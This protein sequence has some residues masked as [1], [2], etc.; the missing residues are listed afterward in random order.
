MRKFERPIEI[1]EMDGCPVAVFK[2]IPRGGTTIG[3]CE[4]HASY[5]NGRPPPFRHANPKVG[6]N[7][8][9]PCGSEKKSKK[10]CKR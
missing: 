8:P 6:R 9:C 3:V 1:C 4:E 10:C 5:P 7:D 2:Y